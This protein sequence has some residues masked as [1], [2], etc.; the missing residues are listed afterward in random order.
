MKSIIL[1][2][3]NQQSHNSR[4]DPYIGRMRTLAGDI[5]KENGVPEFDYKKELEVLCNWLGIEENYEMAHELVGKTVGLTGD[6]DIDDQVISG[7]FAMCLGNPVGVVS[8]E[9][10]GAAIYHYVPDDFASKS[11]ISGIYDVGLGG[12][13]PMSIGNDGGI[14]GK[15]RKA[16]KPFQL[17]RKSLGNR[18]VL[19][20]GEAGIKKTATRMVEMTNQYVRDKKFAEDRKKLSDWIKKVLQLN[21]VGGDKS[22]HLA[23]IAGVLTNPQIVRYQK[24]PV[25]LKMDEK[26]GKIKLSS[27]EWLVAPAR[28]LESGIADCDDFT[29]V[30]GTVAQMLGLDVEYRIAKCNPGNKNAYSHVYNV[31]GYPAGRVDGLTGEDRV[32][33][34][35]VYMKRLR[36]GNNYMKAYGKEPKTYGA[37]D[38]QVN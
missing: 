17:T 36:D 29:L 15:R 10:G 37:M 34:D 21:N 18:E 14:N 7:A 33:V 26:D 6:R 32:V 12:W 24:D 2:K 1:E 25:M 31:I 30:I 28:T 22:K 35:I 4:N 11:G 20:G 3:L 5:F 27:H 8:D 19:D 9:L 23:A 13:F 38:Y 16:Y